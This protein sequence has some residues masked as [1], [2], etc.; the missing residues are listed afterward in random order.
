MLSVLMSLV[1]L[2]QSI[3]KTTN[4]PV[5][6]EVR[7]CDRDNSPFDDDDYDDDDASNSLPAAAASL[8]L[9]AT[10]ASLM[11]DVYVIM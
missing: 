5:R 10:A 4:N 6:V 9:T 1:S 3:N 11:L 8:L 7:L 2:I